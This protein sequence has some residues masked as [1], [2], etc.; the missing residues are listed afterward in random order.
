MQETLR[1]DLAGNSPEWH[2]EELRKTEQAIATGAAYFVDWEDAKEELK[3]DE[4]EDI[5]HG[6]QGFI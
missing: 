5:K 2:R 3:R 6:D 1:S 4:V